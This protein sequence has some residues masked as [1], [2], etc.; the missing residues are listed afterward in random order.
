MFYFDELIVIQ[1]ILQKQFCWYHIFTFWNGYILKWWAWLDFL[2]VLGIIQWYLFK[3]KNGFSSLFKY[4]FCYSESVI[5]VF[6]IWNESPESPQL[7]IELQLM[8]P[9]RRLWGGVF[10]RPHW[11]RLIY[12][13]ISPLWNVS[14]TLHET[15]QRCNWDASKPARLWAKWRPC[16]LCYILKILSFFK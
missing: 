4:F 6:I 5:R 8:F 16:I 9:H 10:N 1:M 13:Q 15:S 3:R 2:K 14:E 12:L 7:E 11:R